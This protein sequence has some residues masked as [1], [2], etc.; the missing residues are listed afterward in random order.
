VNLRIPQRQD[1]AQQAFY[2]F[3]LKQKAIKA[4]FN[5]KQLLN[6]AGSN[7]IS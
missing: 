3:P 6:G 5:L 2:Y 7:G 1:S 4:L